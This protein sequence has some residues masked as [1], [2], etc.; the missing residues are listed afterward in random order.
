M[1]KLIEYV[2]DTEADEDWPYTTVGFQIIE[3]KER[4]KMAK[5]PTPAPK[6]SK[7]PMKPAKGK[8]GC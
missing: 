5:K 3:P 6:T 7:P 1:D 4:K 2:E 8:S